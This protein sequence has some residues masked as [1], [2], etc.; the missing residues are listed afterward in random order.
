MI[1]SDEM[2]DLVNKYVEFCADAGQIDQRLYSQYD[3]KRGLRESN[4]KGVL[5]GLTEISD[6]NGFR[7][8][9]GERIPIEGELYYQGYSVRDLVRGFH[10]SKHGFEETTFLLLFGE[11]PTEDQLDEFMRVMG[12]LRPLPE[13]FN[14]DVIMKAPSRNIMNVLQRCVLTLYSYDKNPDDISLENVLRQCLTM[15][16][17]FPMLS[18]YGYHAYNHYLKDKSLYIHEPSR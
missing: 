11:L 12:Q 9:N 7:V 5:T 16:S 1:N 2:K 17:V 6:V 10:G 14:R 18:V 15:I 8:E 3:V 13:N 4:G